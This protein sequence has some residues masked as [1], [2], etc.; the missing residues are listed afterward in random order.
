MTEDNSLSD[1]HRKIAELEATVQTLEKDLIHDNLTGLKTRGFFEE[2]A[3]MYFDIAVNAK[4]RGARRTK[5][6]GFT[7]ISFI[8]FDIDF[9]K[10]V[11]DT[12]GHDAGDE[13]LRAVAET[14]KVSVREGD[15]AARWGGE[16]IVVALVGAT[17]RDA[18]NKAEDIRR[19]IEDI[20]FGKFPDL[21][22]TISAGVAA[23]E[24][25]STFEDILKRA[26][27][28]LYKAKETGRNRVVGYSEIN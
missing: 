25:G 26:D 23:A 27:K 6:F 20:I 24:S 22:V 18:K 14:I 1:L 21:H 5:W 9:F 8:F 19:Q 3:R 15:T 4:G 10:K 11:N 2:E 16:E 17:E 28:A 7:N 13:V 12:L